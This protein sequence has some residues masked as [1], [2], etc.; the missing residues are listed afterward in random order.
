MHACVSNVHA[1]SRTNALL[2]HAHLESVIALLVCA[3]P[4][5]VIALLVRAHPE[6]AIALLV[7]ARYVLNYVHV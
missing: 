7:R 3:H 5:S 2:V 4:K 1:Q 6:S